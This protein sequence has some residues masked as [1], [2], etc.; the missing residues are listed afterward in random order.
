MGD[1]KWYYLLGIIFGML[2]VLGVVV[3]F[4]YRE[5]IHAKLA[6]RKKPEAVEEAA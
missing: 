5:D 2:T 1:L 4:M 3:Y 6:E